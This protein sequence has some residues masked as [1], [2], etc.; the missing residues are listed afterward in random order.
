MNTQKLSKKQREILVGILLGDAHLERPYRVVVE[1]GDKHKAY[2]EH[3]LGVFAP[4]VGTT[5]LRA[6]KVRLASGPK[7]SFIVHTNWC[8]KTRHARPFLF[9]AQQFYDP[10]KRVPP[11][12]HRLLTPVQ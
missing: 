7:G 4:F 9:Y 11:L 12:I 2:I 5:Q 10:K 8:F 1:Q 3:L 6:R